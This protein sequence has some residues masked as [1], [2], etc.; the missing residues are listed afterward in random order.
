MSGYTLND[1]IQAVLELGARGFV[2][3][4]YSVETLARSMAQIAKPAR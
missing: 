3:K 1:E 2:T 4:P